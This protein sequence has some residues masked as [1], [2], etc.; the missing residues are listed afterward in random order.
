MAVPGA[1]ILVTG[2]GG[3]V[4]Q[5]LCRRLAASGYGVTGLFR[6]VS[7]SPT[8]MRARAVGDLTKIVDFA[9]FMEGADTVVHL[10]ARVHMM[11]DTAA[12]PEIAFRQANTDVTRNLAQ[13]A[14]S[15]GVGRFVFL[16][17]VKANGE[18][19]SDRAAFSET[20]PPVPED[21]YGRS[22]RDAETA[23]A[24]ISSAT[25]LPVTTLRVPLV[26]GPG[27][28]ANFA[29]L[30]AMSYTPLPLPLTGITANR[31]S[32]LYLGNLTHAIEQVIETGGD[33]S[34]LYLLSDGED[35]STAELVYRLRRSFNRCRCGIPIPPAVLT[36]LAA[37]A[38]KR[39]A[40]DR[41]CGSLQIDS[42]L[43]RTTF[44]WTPP[45]SVDQGLAATAAWRRAST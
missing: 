2:A 9:P 3:F 42:S 37:L 35:L 14:A 22:K 41:L 34:G 12:N 28:R 43:F 44:D 23:L 26:Y 25:G 38:G 19:T 10:A 16:S 24:E 33:R 7:D 17:S 18:S 20:D 39:A 21:A 5:A 40:A 27:V 15:G 31:R 30:M 45:Y 4:G 8:W 13:A 32:L 29:S 6:T 36:G 11:H 1:N